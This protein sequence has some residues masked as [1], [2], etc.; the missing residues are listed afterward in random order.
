[1]SGGSARV[2]GGRYRLDGWLGRGGM[3]AVW[4]AHDTLLGRDVAVK[5]I[6]L[7]GAGEGPAEADEPAIRRAMREAQAAARLRHPGI[8][9]VHDVV[10]QD[11][12]PWIVMELVGGGSLAAAVHEHGLLTEHRCAAVGLQVLDAL[13]AAHRE[14]VLHRDVKPANILLDG[15]RA[16]LTDFGI[17]ALD[18]ATALTATGQMIGSPAYLA[19]ERINGRPATAATDLWALGVTLYT[20]VTG[21]P[22]F[23]GDD[24][25]STLAAVLHQHPETPAHAG[26]L[27]PVI[28][29][30]LVKDPARRL[31]A[32]EARPLL[33]A[34]VRAHGEKPGR[35]R[36]GR[37]ARDRLRP[38]VPEP[39]P[40][41]PAP[42]A[43]VAAPTAVRPPDGPTVAAIPD[44]ATVPAPAT[45]PAVPRRG[46]WIAL[47]A[48]S[49]LLASSAITREVWL[50]AGPAAS[51]TLGPTT[52]ATGSDAGS[53]PVKHVPAA[54]VGRWSGRASQ[55]GGDPASWKVTITFAEA[56]DAGELESS[57]LNC[58]WNLTVVDPA[59]TG[60]EMHQ[61][62][63]KTSRDPR[64][65][66]VT[67]ADMTLRTG[68]GG[69]L[70]MVMQQVGGNA[71]RA[72]ATL[73]R[74]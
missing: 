18:D 50:R 14:G 70:E 23:R 60:R 52:A 3:G 73:T 47:V 28:K 21:R 58:T 6:Y 72:T 40:T 26:Q 48:V 19:P 32:D 63:D 16:V 8:V 49:A 27:W 31:T 15:D 74:S 12:R 71:E 57:T 20:A 37:A 4:Q 64:G 56:S 44:P 51:A 1:M 34:V 65:A 66:C 10:V 41:V 5:E 11:G 39:A 42:A 54:F 35:R 61:R 38:G 22:P 29:G 59:P 30:L 7:P 24:T 25:Q 62:Q 17:A 68:Q 46:P 13:R 69:R 53:P 36:S 55:P 67:T 9:T 2:V 45:D 43:T 33:E